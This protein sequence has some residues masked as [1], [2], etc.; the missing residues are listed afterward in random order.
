[1]KF[2]VPEVVARDPWT[3]LGVWEAGAGTAQQLPQFRGRAGDVVHVPAYQVMVVEFV[4][5][6]LVNTPPITIGSMF[7]FMFYC[8]YIEL[9]GVIT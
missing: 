5:V 3:G 4:V 2:L 8:R 9:V 1:M 7:F 6:K